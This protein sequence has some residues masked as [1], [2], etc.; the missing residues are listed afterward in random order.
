MVRD[1]VL[2]PETIVSTMVEDDCGCCC[3]C[4]CDPE[5]DPVVLVGLVV[6]APPLGVVMVVVDFD[7]D[8][9]GRRFEAFGRG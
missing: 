8:G 9:A 2:V 5:L 1:V 7:E 6:F 4:C 3:C